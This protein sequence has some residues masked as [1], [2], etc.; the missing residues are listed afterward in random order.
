MRKLIN[1]I[2]TCEFGMIFILPISSDWV[3]DYNLFFST[4]NWLIRAESTSFPEY[5]APDPKFYLPFAV[6][7]VHMIRKK[8]NSLYESTHPNLPFLVG[9]ILSKIDIVGVRLFTIYYPN[10]Y[11]GILRKFFNPAKKFKSLVHVLNTKK[12][13]FITLAK[14]LG[15]SFSKISSFS[16][17]MDLLPNSFLEQQNEKNH[18]IL[19]QL[20]GLVLLEEFLMHFEVNSFF[21]T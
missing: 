9:L 8:D 7:L 20:K 10:G 19:W 17:L 3:L 11:V 2:E 12:D 14:E 4:F 5:I 1:D 18:N 15:I 6:C 16:Q 21:I 13:Q